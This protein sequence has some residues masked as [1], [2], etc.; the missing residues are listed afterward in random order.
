MAAL[1]VSWEIWLIPFLLA[2]LGCVIGVL[3]FF[4]IL[5]VRQAGVLIL[6][7]LSPIAIVCYA[8]PNTKN[9]F[10][11]WKKM[12]MGLLVVY[13]ICGLLI[14]GGQFASA[15]L[16]SVDEG[17]NF[18][19]DLVAMLVAVVPFFFIPS[20]L[21]GSMV[22]MGNLGMKIAGFGSRFSTGLRRTIGGAEGVR[23][24]QRSLSMHNAEKTFNRL[25][26]RIERGSK[27]R[28]TARRRSNAA[29]R[30]NRLAM[31]DFKA[32]GNQEL[33][34]PGSR[35]MQKLETEQMVADTKGQRD[36]Y[37]AQMNTGDMGAVGAEYEK[38]LEALQANPADRSA[39][40]KVRALQDIMSE[41]DPGR[42]EMR[43]RMLKMAQ[44]Y[45]SF[46]QGVA[47][48]T[49]TALS[50]AA[51][52]LMD[53]YNGLMKKSNRGTW[54]MLG[55]FQG[56]DFAP[57]FDKENGRIIGLD[58]K[59]RPLAEGAS[60]AAAYTSTFYDQL[61]LNGYNAMSLIEADDAV[62]DGIN[63]GI[64]DGSINGANKANIVS[65]ASEAYGNQN[66]HFQPK[67]AEQIRKTL[68]DGNTATTI[69]GMDTGALE[70]LAGDIEK[71]TLA[72]SSRDKLVNMAKTALS[73]PGF[74]TNAEHAAQLNNILAA[75]GKETI[76][77][78]GQIN[79]QSESADSGS[80]NLRGGVAQGGRTSNGII[81]PDGQALDT[82][83][84]ML[85]Q[86][87]AK[88]AIRKANDRKFREK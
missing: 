77:F 42:T 74:V 57:L 13:P 31:E 61:G 5:G 14:G 32:G 66:V 46:Y 52:H 73:T 36:I 53:N 87:Q 67:V 33:L 64:A 60:D 45:S 50:M 39:F 17:T 79:T 25:D 30:Y 75:A 35:G 21:R 88:D 16:V 58:S 11:K 26:R 44:K 6:V 9:L 15:L 70:R 8:L 49:D 56:G 28:L 65:L 7:A 12:F 40:V 43:N 55:H 80:I 69:G 63:R 18:F 4:V 34:L 41:S 59:G 62:R 81:L 2:L 71:G 10:D 20:I 85:R 22:A 1:V 29:A 76:P 38:Q 3:F 82:V 47:P 68:I 78:A 48:G 84:D 54:S 27:S 51:G 23:E 24:A 86:D 72:G 19:Y 37:S 83:G